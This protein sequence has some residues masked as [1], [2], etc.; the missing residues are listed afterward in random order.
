MGNVKDAIGVIAVTLVSIL[1]ADTF[2]NMG[3]RTSAASAASLAPTVGA[4][5]RVHLDGAFTT[6]ITSGK[7][8]HVHIS[9][10][11]DAVRA[12]TT[13]VKDGTL[14]VGER[15]G[16]Y[17]IHTVNLDITVAH[18]RSFSNGGAGT[19]TIRGIA[20]DI[21]IENSGAGSIDA[22][23][24]SAHE[25]VELAGVGQIDTRGIDAHDVSVASD[26]VGA[27]YVRGSGAL[28]LEVNGVG[29]IRYAG[30]PTTVDRQ[31]NG[32]GSIG[33]I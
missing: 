10:D 4:F 3:H 2:W 26:G 17:G 11:P 33:P 6:T 14:T 22:Y 13:S 16:S 31:V 7:S 32:L 21:E 23:G 12:V 1:V 30:H 19:T 18:L 24:R 9:G 20:D 8:P 15:N 25:S 28:S 27:V 5:D 29:E